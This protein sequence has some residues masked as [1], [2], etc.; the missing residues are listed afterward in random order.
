MGG[1]VVITSATAAIDTACWDIK[2][3]ALGVPVYKLL[4]GKT[5]PKLRAYASQ[6]QFG[7]SDLIQKDNKGEALGLLFDPKDYYEVTKNALRDGYD[8]IKVDPV[9]LPPIP[10][11]RS[12]RSGAARAPRSAAAI[13]SATCSAR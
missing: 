12:K 3:K 9:L 6:L 7:W 11:P 2:G 5:N 4:G 10:T 13:V 8:A 1:G